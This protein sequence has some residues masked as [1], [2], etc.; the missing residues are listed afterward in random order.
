MGRH[1]THDDIMFAEAATYIHLLS[2]LALI[3]AVPYLSVYVFINLFF[4]L[5]GLT[6]LHDIYLFVIVEIGIQCYKGE[7]RLIRS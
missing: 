2:V 3:M 1:T 4:L 5:V 6:V 7:G